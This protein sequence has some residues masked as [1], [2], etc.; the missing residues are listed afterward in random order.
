MCILIFKLCSIKLLILHGK[1]YIIF[2][3][4]YM[5]ALLSTT[6]VVVTEHLPVKELV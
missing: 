6:W 3:V 5:T 2:I 4:H 1:M